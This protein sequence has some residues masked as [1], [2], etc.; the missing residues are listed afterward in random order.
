MLE[1]AVNKA[2]AELLE[3]NQKLRDE[4]EH[5]K[6]I[7]NHDSNNCGMPTS[8]TPIGKQKRIPNSRHESS[9]SKGGQ[10]GHKK[11]KLEKFSDDEITETRTYSID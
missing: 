10:L 9:K 7:L 1:Q 6:R 4:M 11:S 5:L 2:N 8:K 3:E